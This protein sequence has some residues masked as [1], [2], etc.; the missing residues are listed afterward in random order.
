MATKKDMMKLLEDTVRWYGDTYIP[1]ILKVDDVLPGNFRKI[2]KQYDLPQPNVPQ[3]GRIW[4]IRENLP[5]RLRGRVTVF[6]L[7]IAKGVA[8][9]IIAVGSI[10]SI[11][12]SLK[13][14]FNIR[15]V[16]EGKYTVIS[17]NR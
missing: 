10:T 9:T 14:L 16:F 3:P 15:G 5:S 17:T 13:T 6:S 12:T 8:K 1:T 7:C 4:F 11:C 2:L